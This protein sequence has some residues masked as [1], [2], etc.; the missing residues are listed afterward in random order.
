MSIFIYKNCI[1]YIFFFYAT[2]TFYSKIL[3]LYAKIYQ[4]TDLNRLPRRTAFML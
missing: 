2:S 1:Y 3:S 4:L